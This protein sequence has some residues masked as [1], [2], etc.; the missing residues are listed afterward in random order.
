MEQYSQGCD[1][2]SKTVKEYF[3]ILEETLV[4]YMIIAYT[5]KVKRT[6]WQVSH[7]YYFGLCIPNFLL[8]RKNLQQATTDFGKIFERLMVQEIVAY[9]GYHFIEGRIG[10]HVLNLKLMLSLAMHLWP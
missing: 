2:D 5:K 6:L 8:N 3:S 10:T 7:F 9:M 1:I 4:G